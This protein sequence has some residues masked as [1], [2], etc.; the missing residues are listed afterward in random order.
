M[1][2]MKEHKFEIFYY[3]VMAEVVE[4]KYNSSLS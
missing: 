4:I 1:N 2:K 3:F